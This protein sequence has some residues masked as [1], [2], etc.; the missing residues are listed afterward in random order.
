[1]KKRHRCARLREPFTSSSSSSSKLGQ[2]IEDEEE[3]R[4]SQMHALSVV[5]IPASNSL[6][7]GRLPMRHRK[8]SDQAANHSTNNHYHQR[9]ACVVMGKSSQNPPPEKQKARQATHHQ[10][11]DETHREREKEI[12][13]LLLFHGLKCRAD[14]N[15]LTAS[16]PDVACHRRPEH[17]AP[18]RK[19]LVYRS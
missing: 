2:R 5:V 16:P 18:T 12:R 11:A 10:P 4:P 13:P 6:V 14:S 1:M 8:Y 7:P 17:A 3:Q 15:R 9:N 19:P